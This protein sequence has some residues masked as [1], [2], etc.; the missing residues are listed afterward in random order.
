MELLEGIKTRR[1][2]R[3]FKDEKVSRETVEKIIES[4]RMAPSWKNTQTARYIVVEGE[5]K[6][7]IAEE[8]V[9]GFQHNTDIIKGAP[10]LVVLASVAKRSGYERDGSFTTSKGQQW[11]MFDAGIAAQTFSLAAHNEGVGSVILG[12]FDDTKVAEL[13]ELPEGQNVSALIPIGYSDKELPEVPR[14]SVEDLLTFK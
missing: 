6:D 2:V 8:A 1:S 4:A 11:E 3:S 14:K 13:I 10:Q 9:L 5:L 7:K 12:I